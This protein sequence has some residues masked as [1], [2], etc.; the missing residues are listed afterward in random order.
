LI[1]ANAI[2]AIKTYTIYEARA[3]VT[4]KHGRPLLWN[5]VQIETKESAMWSTYGLNTRERQYRYVLEMGEYEESD[6]Q[7]HGRYDAAVEVNVAQKNGA[8]Q[9]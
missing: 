4:A 8:R 6:A 3:R 5:T 1:E 2:K 9:F 7:K